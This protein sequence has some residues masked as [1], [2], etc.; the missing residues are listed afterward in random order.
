MV[1]IVLNLSGI[2][3]MPTG[4]A[5]PIPFPYLKMGN[6][7]SFCILLLNSMTVAV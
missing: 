1:Q 6:I 4:I 7:Y 2:G 3:I 5:I